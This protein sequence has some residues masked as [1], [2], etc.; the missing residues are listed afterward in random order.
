MHKFNGAIQTDGIQWT[1]ST[2][3]HALNRK[4]PVDAIGPAAI[5]AP[6]DRLALADHDII[7]ILNLALP[8]C[9]NIVPQDLHHDRHAPS[10]LVVPL[11]DAICQWQNGGQ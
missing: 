4:H 1:G 10:G 2:Y 6:P 7:F 9:K 3:W 5:P 11:L 8:V